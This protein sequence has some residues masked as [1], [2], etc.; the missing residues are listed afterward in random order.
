MKGTVKSGLKRGRKKKSFLLTHKKGKRN[1]V[2]RPYIPVG[3]R[4]QYPD[5]QDDEGFIDGDDEY[6]NILQLYIFCS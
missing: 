2:Q 3:E 5:L 6:G 1:G 4:E